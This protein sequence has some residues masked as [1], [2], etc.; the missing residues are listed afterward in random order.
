[1]T[2]LQATSIE[3]IRGAQSN[4]RKTLVKNRNALKPEDQL[5][6]KTQSFEFIFFYGISSGF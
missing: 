3:I 4:T 1:M 2:D 5:F 6:S